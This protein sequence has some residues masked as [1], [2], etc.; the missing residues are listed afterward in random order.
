MN[1]ELTQS[2]KEKIMKLVLNNHE[3]SCAIV[4]QF[5][6]NLQLISASDFAKLKGK[7]KRTILYQSK[8]LDGI[9]IDNRKYFVFSQ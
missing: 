3:K 5:I 4:Q 8:K 6:D 1:Q 2:E 9:Q 7:S